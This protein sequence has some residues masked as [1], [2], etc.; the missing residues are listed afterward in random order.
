[1]LFVSPLL[2]ILPIP[3]G[4]QT[5]CSPC[6]SSSF[7]SCRSSTL[8]ELVT[9][10]TFSGEDAAYVGDVRASLLYGFSVL[11][12]TKSALS[13]CS[14]SEQAASEGFANPVT[15]TAY[16]QKS[17]AHFSPEKQHTVLYTGAPLDQ[18]DPKH[19]IGI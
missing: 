7:Y 11:I 18:A 1:M 19:V 10:A 17:D 9:P 12:R 3:S 13:F 16:T 2:L 4:P 5:Q 6:R 14:G 8:L 15:A